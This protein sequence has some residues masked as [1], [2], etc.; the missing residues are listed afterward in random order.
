MKMHSLSS[1]VIPEAAGAISLRKQSMK[2]PSR[3]LVT[4]FKIYLYN[5]AEINCKL[6]KWTFS[7]VDGSVKSALKMI[8]PST[9][10]MGSRSI[11]M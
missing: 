6:I 7:C 5:D 3:D 8:A 1:V 4:C 9:L 2:R 11:A 10:D